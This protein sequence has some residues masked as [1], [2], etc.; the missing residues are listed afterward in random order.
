MNSRFSGSSGFGAWFGKRAVGLEVETL[1]LELG[2]VLEHGREHHAGHP[3]RGVDHDLERLDRLDVDE[4]ERALDVLLP[5]VVRL[6]LSRGQ[7]LG[8]GRIGHGPVADLQQAGLAAD[9]E[10]ALADDLQTRVLLRVMRGRD[11][12]PAVEPQ[13]ADREIDHLRPDEAEL[14]HVRARLGRAG[15]RRLG[16][17]GRGDAHVVP[18]GDPLRPEHLDEGPPDRT[19][20]LLVELG[21]V[22][23]AD[24][25]CLENL[26]VEHAPML[27]QPRKEA[28]L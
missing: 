15:D 16:H 14:E 27:C 28:G 26:G 7:S 23:P 21:S 4:R 3:V 9:R 24:V 5:D 1:D 11:R 18:D 2:Q 22:D 17:R 13:L 20:A 6:D 12:D 10:R 25:V 19:R 8:R